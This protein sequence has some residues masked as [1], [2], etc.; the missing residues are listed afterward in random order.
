MAVGI[1]KLICR[2]W[3]EVKEFCVDIFGEDGVKTDYQKN[4]II[5]TNNCNYYSTPVVCIHVTRRWYQNYKKILK[6]V[7][8]ISVLFIVS[9]VYYPFATICDSVIIPDTVISL[10]VRKF[11]NYCECKHNTR[12]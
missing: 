2:L 1:E 6:F 3:T 11:L 4:L 9:F 10:M 12:F 8:R 7:R 5:F